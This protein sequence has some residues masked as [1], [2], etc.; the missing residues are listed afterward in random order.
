M[1]ELDTS[2][3]DRSNDLPISRRDVMLT[4]V[5]ITGATLAGL[6]SRLQAPGQP[7][8]VFDRLQRGLPVAA[9]PEYESFVSVSY[10]AHFVEVRVE[11]TTRRV[12]VPRIVSVVDCGRVVSPRTAESQFRGG[13]VWGIGAALR[14]TADIDS[15]FGGV[16]NNDF[17]EYLVPVNADI[18]AIEVAFIDRPGPLIN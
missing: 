18:G 11:P 10:I 9:G 12:R 2:P 15:R 4:G 6:E 13:V 17:A 7:D 16:L 5:A 1:S 8:S 14:E 3:H